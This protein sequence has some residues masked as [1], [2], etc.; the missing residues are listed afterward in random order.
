VSKKGLTQLDDVLFPV[1]VRPVFAGA[2]GDAGGKLLSVPDKKAIVDTQ[3]RRVLGIVS[4]DYRL[5]SNREALDWA[6]QCCRTVFPEA[7]DTEWE[8]KAT[9]APGTSFRRMAA[10]RSSALSFASPTATTA[11][12]LWPSISAFFGRSAKTG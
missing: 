6:Y 9:D 3:R 10:P 1:E 11:C 5:V 4:R 8:V 12:A 2:N 7:K